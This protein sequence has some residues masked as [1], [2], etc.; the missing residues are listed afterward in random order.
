[1]TLRWRLVLLHAGVATL[2]IAASGVALVVGL[3]GRLVAGL[4]RE[5]EARARAV[6]VLVEHEGG[7]WSVEPDSGLEVEFAAASGRYFLV[8]D[9]AQ[10]QLAIASA[11][12]RELAVVASSD[13]GARDVVRGGR[14]Y[15][16]VAVVLEKPA[17]EEERGVGVVV[18]VVCG[19]DSASIDASVASVIAQLAVVF[20]I[21][22]A[23]VLAGG[24]FL[25][26]RA[27]A[28]IDRMARVAAE[29]EARDL[30]RRLGVSGSDEIAR[31]AGTLDALFARLEAAFG[32][33]AR[34]TADASHELRTPLAVIAGEVEL[35]L[36]RPRG[37]DEYRA[38]LSEV[39]GATARM[40]AV[41]E[42]LLVLARVDAG[43]LVLARG[44]V[45]LRALVERVVALHRALALECQVA[46]EVAPGAPVEVTGD[47]DR[48]HDVVANL[49]ANAI[50]YTEAGGTV[51]V[52]VSREPSRARI[53]IRDT[54]IGIAPADLGRIFER[55]YRADPARSRER[56]GTGLGLAIAMEIARAHGGAIE[57]EST[58]GVGSQFTVTLPA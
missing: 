35:A 45:E 3:R 43:E 13:E 55:F 21:A 20:P 6:C 8:T 42:G 28:P 54:G 16:E 34:F 23:F 25:A 22:L 36:K 39:A 49:V 14:T 58:L 1:M 32:R 57:V 33:Q 38:A 51:R 10:G 11:L 24:L 5:L 46:L 2:A 41:V 7:R 4:D 26:S 17:D 37:A 44:R 15:R 12:A 53:A 19:A 30:S 56:G 18:R 29:I 47:P 50:R 40:R 9:V 48:L 52:E 31:L 27:L